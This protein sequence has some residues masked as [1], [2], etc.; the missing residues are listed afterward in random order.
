MKAELE[1]KLAVGVERTAGIAKRIGREL[2]SPSKED[3][4]KK[5]LQRLG[6][7]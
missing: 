1:E 7:V 3:L 5:R 2:Y 4:C 6:R